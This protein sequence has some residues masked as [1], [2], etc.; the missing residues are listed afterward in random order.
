MAVI[1]LMQKQF[2]EALARLVPAIEWQRKALTASPRNP[3]FRQYLA[4]HL[5]NFIHANEGLGHLDEAEKTRVELK[6]LTLNDPRFAQLDA[7]LES[8]L[9]GDAPKSNAERLVMAQRAYDKSLYAIAARLWTE[10]VESDPKLA[11]DRQAGHRYNA[12]C[13]AALTANGKAKDE[14][15]PDDGARSKLRGKAARL[16]EGRGCG[17]VEGHRQRSTPGTASDRS[18]SQTLERGLGSLQRPRRKRARD[19][20][21]S[22][23]QR[24][25]GALERGRWAVEESGGEGAMMWD[26]L[27]SS[28]RCTV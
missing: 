18:N 1:H 22:R 8:V 10:A 25:A 24:M 15:T 28:E 27:S 17:L 21:R 2:A 12:A 16:P 9:K 20:A 19:A 6:E 26:L 5:T 11:E 14:R 4:N 23:A 13:S 7:R 3:T